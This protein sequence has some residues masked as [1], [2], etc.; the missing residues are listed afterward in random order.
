[1]KSIGGKIYTLLIAIA[2]S[3]FLYI[4]V[5][6]VGMANA[7]N[8]LNTVSEHYMMMQV[9]NEALSRGVAEARLYANIMVM[10]DTQ[11]GTAVANLLPNQIA[12]IQ[13]TIDNMNA[14]LA[15]ANNETLSA[16]FGEYEA[17]AETLFAKITEAQTKYL[18]GDIASAGGCVSAMQEI[19]T[20]M[21]EK[22]TIFSDTLNIEAQTL[23]QTATYALNM[24]R[25][26][27]GAVII[28]I[29]CTV[30]VLSF[31]IIRNTIIKPAKNATSHLTQIIAG[32]E[33]GEGNL[34]ERLT[35]KGKDEIA[36]LSLGINAFLDQLQQIMLKLRDG[37]QGMGVQVHNINNSIETSEGSASDVSATMEE[38]SASMEEIAATL[39]Q[40]TTG[41]RN[42][43]TNAQE[44][45]GLANDG[46]NFAEEIKQKARVLRE[47][48]IVSK[49]NTIEMIS[50]NKAQ[51]E[52]SIEN[53]RSV[54]KIN[55]LTGDILDIASQTNLLALNASIEAAR[56]GEAGKGFAVVADEIRNLA[57]NSTQTA[58]NIQE[59]SRLVTQAVEI[60]AKNANGVLDFID[61]T[62]LVDYDK[63]VDV[64]TQYHDDADNIDEMM[65]NFREKAGDLENTISDMSE[66]I[67]GINTAL[68]ENVQGVTL[69]ADSTSQL[70]EL[71]G[72]MRVE[73]ENNL[74]ISN[75][76]SNEVQQ[77]KHI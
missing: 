54:E 15:S 31:I 10:R 55:E 44:M 12:G 65:N 14:V 5:A 57:D 19:T 69:V 71:L 63:L 4:V 59:I 56:A 62:V 64:S 1:M 40:I 66:G 46:A 37:S 49:N 68:D 17:L 51:L 6:S 20:A 7:N 34:T 29:V 3:A 39:N 72:N 74:E 45:R 9:H 38:M 32:I 41:S 16:A 30:T 18:G 52:I 47:D 42:V 25:N 43:L 22:Q 58:N 33:A 26:T 60:L 8:A 77:F 11:T 75:E 73:A 76:L 67:D 23:T 50:N 48:A 61:N 27:I 53:S 35:V 70:V 2:V 13:A 21:Q 36:Q 24:I 28:L